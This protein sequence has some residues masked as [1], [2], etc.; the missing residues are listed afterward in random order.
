MRF[1]VVACVMLSRPGAVTRTKPAY[2]PPIKSPPSTT[3]PIPPQHNRPEVVEEVQGLVSALVTMP[4]YDPAKASAAVTEEFCRT[5]KS[6][7][8][9]YVCI[10]IYVYMY[11]YRLMYL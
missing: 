9:G 6:G 5:G 8:V 2:P 10:Y 1:L 7:W 11:V 3:I 4:E